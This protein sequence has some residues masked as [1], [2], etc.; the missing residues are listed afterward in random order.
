M[1]SFFAYVIRCTLPVLDR[2]FLVVTRMF[3]M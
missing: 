2:V 3:F 1:P